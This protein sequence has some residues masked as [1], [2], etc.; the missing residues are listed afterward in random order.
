M[1][2]EGLER[3]LRALEAGTIRVVARDLTE[4]SPLALECSP[5]ARMP[6]STTHRS[7]SGARRP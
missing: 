7:K 6:I 4:P 2:I 3:L 1:D 5:H